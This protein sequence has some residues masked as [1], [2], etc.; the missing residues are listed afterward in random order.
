MTP[1]DLLS[2]QLLL[3]QFRKASIGTTDLYVIID[4]LKALATAISGTWSSGATAPSNANGDNGNYYFNTVAGTLY[5]K[6]AG[7]WNLIYTFG[8]GSGTVTAVTG[9]APVLSSGG[10]APIISMHVADA[11][12]DGYL[13]SADWA[14]FGAAV[15]TLYTA[16]GSLTG[17]RALAGG[18]FSLLMSALSSFGVTAT[19]GV[20]LTSSGATATVLGNTAASIG[21]SGG[22]A[23]AT[24]DK[25]SKITQFLNHT[26]LTRIDAN[27]NILTNLVILNDGGGNTITNSICNNCT[28]NWGGHTGCS[29]DGSQFESGSLIRFFLDNGT[30]SKSNVKAGGILYVNTTQASGISVGEYAQLAT[31]SGN[32]SGI[33]VFAG[34]SGMTVDV[35]LSALI[36]ACIN[37][38]YEV[39]HT[40]TGDESGLAFRKDRAVW[41]AT[42]QAADFSQQ[43]SDATSYPS[44]YNVDVFAYVRNTD[45]TAGVVDITVDFNDG[46]GSRSLSFGTL[47]LAT[48]GVLRLPQPIYAIDN[49]LVTATITGSYG[50]AQFNIYTT[51]TKLN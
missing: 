38:I 37:N 26:S 10:T 39:S 16:D 34:D 46:S 28:I 8:S 1:N 4:D 9:T 49:I 20:G 48:G 14:A 36:G 42:M 51:T 6:T 30:A 33:T 13:S 21:T 11:T 32:T 2:L 18:G 29:I 23:Y 17:N 24:F 22:E 15:A 19:G 35:D 43:V 3:K 50:S 40:A 44:M 31:G 5:L 47:N 27:G 12:H 41:N 45:V 25:E 7:V